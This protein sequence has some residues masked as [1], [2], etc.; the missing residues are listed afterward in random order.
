MLLDL[1][2]LSVS[3]HNYRDGVENQK[4]FSVPFTP[5]DVISFAY[6][7]QPFA[8]GPTLYYALVHEFGRPIGEDA[9]DQLASSFVDM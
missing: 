3:L 9:F 1:E 7:H 6:S 8:P 5:M 2:I 4:L